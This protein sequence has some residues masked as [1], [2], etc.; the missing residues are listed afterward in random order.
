MV[1]S[2]AQ[3]AS[4]VLE[5]AATQPVKGKGLSALLSNTVQ[6]KPGR[7]IVTPDMARVYLAA[8]ETNRP[9]SRSAVNRLK[10]ILAAGEWR[11]NGEAIK[12]SKE[13]KLLDGQHRLTAIAESDVSAELMVVTDLQPEAFATLDQGRK[14]SGGDVLHVRG[15]ARSQHV[16][17]ACAQL[18]KIMRNK[19][20][21]GGNSPIPAYG[22]DRIFARHPGLA[23]AVEFCAPIV[24][25][26]ENAVIGLGYLAAYLYVGQSIL[27]QKE[28]AAAFAE[29]MATGVDL[30]DNSPILQFRHKV[31][32]SRSGKVMQAQA[33]TAL[34]AK[35]F[36]LF[37]GERVVKTLTAPSPTASYFDLI[38][39]L[40]AKL[41]AFDDA[42]SMRDLPY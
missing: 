1:A 39:E 3:R 30:A 12:F 32:G 28:R 33:K 40:P 21:Y 7:Q 14:R 37:M 4:A 26:G 27:N 11:Y 42:R 22:T 35:T 10:S 23:D 41:E 38:P 36:G 25:R 20:I 9:I 6:V 17:V 16:A 31:L 34:F 15:V 13:G 29:G 8:N 24:K 18:Y 19:P 5:Q 2:T